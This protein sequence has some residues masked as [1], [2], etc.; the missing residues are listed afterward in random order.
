M[1]RLKQIYHVHN[2]EIFKEYLGIIESKSLR[3]M[4]KLRGV[5]NTK[6]KSGNHVRNKTKGIEVELKKGN[7]KFYNIVY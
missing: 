4:N 6:M 7:N 1:L 3:E 5:F 2:G